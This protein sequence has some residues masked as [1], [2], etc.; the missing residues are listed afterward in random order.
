[1]VCVTAAPSIKPLPLTT[2]LPLFAKLYYSANNHPMCQSLRM[3]FTRSRISSCISVRFN[4]NERQLQMYLVPTWKC[5]RCFLS[6][7]SMNDSRI[8]W[9]SNHSLLQ[10]FPLIPGKGKLAVPHRLLKK[11]KLGLYSERACF[12]MAESFRRR[13]SSQKTERSRP[14]Q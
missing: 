6:K 8:D 11:R 7:M 1:M 10:F 5:H 14:K 2:S 13:A 12:E 3:G 9:K 4:T